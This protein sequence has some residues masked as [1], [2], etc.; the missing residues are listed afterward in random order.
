[1]RRGWTITSPS[2]S[3][4]VLWT[5]SWRNTSESDA[6][7]ATRPLIWRPE[8]SVGAGAHARTVRHRVGLAV[9]R[10]PPRT[11][12][13]PSHSRH[14]VRRQSEE[15]AVTAMAA[16]LAESASRF[17]TTTRTTRPC[18]RRSRETDLTSTPGFD[19]TPGTAGDREPRTPHPFA[20][21]GGAVAPSPD[22]GRRLSTRLAPRIW[23]TPMRNGTY[24]C[25]VEPAVPAGAQGARV[26]LDHSGPRLVAAE[27]PLPA[28]RRATLPEKFV[29]LIIR[30]AAVIRI[31]DES[32]RRPESGP[33]LLARGCPVEQCEAAVRGRRPGTQTFFDEPAGESCSPSYPLFV[34]FRCWALLCKCSLRRAAP[35]PRSGSCTDPRQRPSRSMAV[36]TH[37]S[38]R[39]SAQPAVL[40]TPPGSSGSS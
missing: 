17:S 38:R 36:A 39:C 2:Q 26:G 7:Q 8:D 9:A 40:S 12:A 31:G 30:S 15:W 28:A 37:G 27:V 25:P 33:R 5:R 34:G 3:R 10:W 22:D 35:T 19:S 21:A 14:G 29:S 13:G 32:G 23:S 18:A 16:H 6:R 1:M 4:S 11:K 24:L 20:G